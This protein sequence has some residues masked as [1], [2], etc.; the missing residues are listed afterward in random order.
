[1]ATF[2]GIYRSKAVKIEGQTL[3]AQI[4]QVYGEAAVVITEFI[5]SVPTT[6]GMG[7]VS[8]R[9]GD[10]AFPVWHGG[11][12][13][14]D[15][16]P[17]P[18]GPPGGPGE[19]GE[20]GDT[21]PP[22]V[23]VPVG[24]TANQVL[25]KIDSANYNTQWTTPT[26]EVPAARRIDTTAPLTGG[27]DLSANRNLGV[28][29]FGTAQP[30][31]V[32]QS[33]GGD[34]NFL[35]ADGQ[36]A[37]PPGA[38]GG[39]AGITVKEGTTVLG[40]AFTALQFV[41]AGF[42]VSGST[43]AIITLDL[44]EY[45]GSALPITGGGTGATT[46]AAALTALG[47][48][49]ITAL[50]THE[51]DTTAIHGIVDTSALVT[52]T[53]T[54][55][56]TNKTIAFGSNTISGTLTQFNDAITDGD[57]VSTS[58]LGAHTSA[59]TSVHGIADTSALVTLTGNQSLSNKSI[60]F[61]SNTVS[62]TI[63]QFNQA[64]TDADFATLAGTE[65]LTG[66]SINMLNN[67]LTGTAALFNQ[68]LS[69]ADFYLTGGTD[70]AVVDGGTGRSTNVTAYG[71]IAAGATAT[72]AMLTINPGTAG[73][74]LKSAGAGLL[75]SF[76]DLPT[77]STLVSGITRLA[78]PAEAIAGT[79]L[80]T[81][82]VTPA[83]LVSGY[84]KLSGGTLNPGDLSITGGNLNFGSRTGQHLLLYGTTFTVGIQA[85]TF[86]QRTGAG[87]A[88]YLGG[89]HSDTQWAPGA[90]GTELLRL[91]T[92]SFLYK[93]STIWH[94]GNDGASSTLDAD[95][96]DSQHGSYYQ[97]ATN[98]NA[99]T[100]H[101]DRLTGTY[102]ISVT[103]NAGTATTLQ[104]SRNIAGFPFN[105]SANVTLATLTR[106]T[107]LTGANY[108]G[109]LGTTWAV[110]AT[111][112]ATVSKVVARDASG[113][114]FANVFTGT[115]FVSSQ[116]GPTAPF[117]VISQGLVTNLNSDLLDGN[118]A[119]YFTPIELAEY[120]MGDLFFAG[121]YSPANYVGTDAT[122]PQTIYGPNTYRHGMY[123]VCN[124]SAR[125]DFIDAD[126][127]GRTDIDDGEVDVSNGDWIVAIDPKQSYT[128]TVVNKSLTTNVATLTL[129]VTHPLAIG[130]SVT[131]TGVD[132]TFNGTFT[133][134]GVTSTTIRYAKTAANVTT[135][136]SGGSVVVNGHD[137][138]TNHPLADMTFQFL[139]FSSETY[140]KSVIADHR[141]EVDPHPA[142]G[143][144]KHVDADLLFAPIFHH[145]PEDYAEIIAL[146]TNVT[147]TPDPHSQYLT[148]ARGGLYF[149]PIDTNFDADILAFIDEHER[150]ADP[151]SQYLDQAEG[152]GRYEPKGLLAA[153]VAAL[154]PH[155]QYMTTSEGQM[156]FENKNAVAVHE[157]KSDPH[158]QYLTPTRGDVRYSLL[159]HD[160]NDLYYT[161]AQVLSLIV[162]TEE[163]VVATDGAPSSRVFIGQKPP[164]PLVGDVLIRTIAADAQPPSAPAVFV[165][166]TTVY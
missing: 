65:I 127:S 76:A 82:A 75:G 66:K 158:V 62:G 78:T 85:S 157:A 110:D 37:L 30:G 120:L 109:S 155:S 28:N 13:T 138:G 10:A 35:R 44:N 153:H 90:G 101:T 92:S 137:A 57:L 77:A 27:G 84:L 22:G 53:G 15:G 56:L 3:T 32:P 122:K 146:H 115:R 88:W 34:V 102:S 61:G 6:P 4:P 72:S 89:V 112:A 144:L 80:D 119:T 23:G 29:Q 51:A 81:I 42:D 98:L 126:L 40:S 74:F 94:A 140:I 18:P 45:T 55:T 149:L 147:A 52:L 67:T 160:H 166:E 46:A 105:G 141:A 113:D 17:G 114:V 134:T 148:V 16:E 111:T 145:H 133:L 132:A 97:N 165:Y 159:T 73:Q 9:S 103:G 117:T 96:L 70:V 64:L 2:S 58:T 12:G 8:F 39:I 99:G 129:S 118:H 116:T 36:W 59:T 121:L 14:G 108:D 107:Y 106:G 104:T 136:A 87:F 60:T 1:V 50:S 20:Q 95:L 86:Y 124:S 152:D 164:S 33:G 11:G 48:A 31:V 131:V 24:G 54:Q 38:G 21:G 161:K 93:G 143:Y 79:P 43:E 162:D 47:A 71:L 26:G 163:E 63:A 7:Y 128:G 5:G 49:S 100:V 125:L 19:P 91:D 154:D 25:S 156:L 151:H 150:K 83:G 68:A 41:A 123:W 135:V 142:A 139:P 69:D 130:D